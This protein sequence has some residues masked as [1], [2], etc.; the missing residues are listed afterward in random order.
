MRNALRLV[1]FAALVALA[2]CSMQ[3]PPG[4]FN[5]TVAAKSPGEIY[6]NQGADICYVVNGVQGATLSLTQGHTYTFSI[7]AP[8]HP[9]YISDNPVGGSGTTGEVTDGV[10]GN[11]TEVGL[12]TYT[13][14][15]A[16]TVYYVCGVHT[17]MG[18]TI[19][20]H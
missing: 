6:Y 12:L 5:V 11:G 13:P 9:F 8:G 17:Y 18:G 10:T 1:V 14:G 15:A 19:N 16:G 2:S 3:V 20:I 4:D 7:N